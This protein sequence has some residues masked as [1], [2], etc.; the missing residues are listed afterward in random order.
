MAKKSDDERD[1]VGKL[2]YIPPSLSLSPL[3]CFSRG[4]KYHLNAAYVS[5][6]M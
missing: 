3:L 5:L 1:L 6:L 2:R 4:F